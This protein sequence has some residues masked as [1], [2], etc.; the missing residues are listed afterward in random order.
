MVYLDYSA[1]TPVNDEV[2]GNG[3]LTYP[4]GLPTIDEGVLAGGIFPN[5]SYYLY[6]GY[7]FHTMSSRMFEADQSTV[8]IIDAGGQA[9]GAT[10]YD[11]VENG[12]RPVINLKPGVLAKGSG[13]ASDP[14][15]VN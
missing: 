3:D 5:N 2:I 4:I 8:H 13:S 10:S 6:T 9:G 15:M 11:T 1:T 7:C 12:V 14:W